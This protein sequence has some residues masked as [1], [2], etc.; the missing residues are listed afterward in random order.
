MLPDRRTF[1]LFALLCGW[2]SVLVTLSSA[3]ADTETKTKARTGGPGSISDPSEPLAAGSHWRIQSSS[4]PAHVWIPDHYQPATAGLVLYVHG[5]RADVDSAWTEHQLARQFAESGVN[6]LFIVPR[7][8]KNKHQRVRA[9]DI[10]A[11]VR[12]V[13]QATGVERPLGPV[14]AVGHSGAYR[15]LLS[16]L[17][18]PDLEEIILLDGLYAQES[19]FREWLERPDENHRL[20]LVV[21]D[22]IEAGDRWM[23][24]VAGA[25]VLDWVP[26]QASD[27]TAAA[28]N[29]RLLY[30]HSQYGHM[31]MVTQAKVIPLL[32]Q[33]TR[34]PALDA[35]SASRGAWRGTRFP[36]KRFLRV[37][38]LIPGLYQCATARMTRSKGWPRY[39]SA[40]GTSATSAAST[41]GSTSMSRCNPAPRSAFT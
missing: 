30:I 16:W 24:D 31:E 25:E 40:L 39:L 32:L 34:L 15:T 33:A 21:M 36:S 3:R 41:R 17:D 20:T 26:E 13:R 5:Y 4:G 27:L 8:P 35:S 7:A 9:R 11:L 6:A 18:D 38:A 10:G 19:R 2:T 22:T 12:D 14:V 23:R 29:A 28:R 1:A 37:R